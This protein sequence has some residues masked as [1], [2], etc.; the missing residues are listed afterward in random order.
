LARQLEYWIVLV[1]TA[2]V[3]LSLGEQCADLRFA[4][5]GEQRQ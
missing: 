1:A 2:T 5:D 4:A 3:E